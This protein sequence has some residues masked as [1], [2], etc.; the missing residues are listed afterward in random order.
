MTVS[1]GSDTRIDATLP[2]GLAPGTYL[3]EVSRGQGNAQSDAFAVAVGAVGPPGEKG[4]KG[5]PGEKGEKGDRGPCCKNVE[6]F[7]TGV[8]GSGFAS[9]T[10]FSIDEE[11]LV[12][13]VN[14]IEF[15][16]TNTNPRDSTNP[17]GLRV[18]FTRAEAHTP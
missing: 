16:V 3:L 1:G 8:A 9:F 11:L 6:V 2:A 10:P 12:A 14:T 5:D 13:G 7:N 18:E 4:E 15:R 17:T